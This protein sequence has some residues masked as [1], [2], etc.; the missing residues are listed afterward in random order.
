MIRKEELTVERFAK[1]FDMAVLAPDTQEEAIRQACR[2][3]AAHN[4]AAMYT[5]PC[6]TKVVAEELAGTDVRVGV[7]ISFPYGTLTTNMKM[8][9]IDD[10]IAN[11]GNSLDMVINIGALK[12]GNIDLVREEI[13]GLVDKAKAAGALSK[14][15]IEVGYLTD[16][17]IATVTKIVS[18][19]GADYVKTATGSAGLPDVH[20]LKVM[21]ANVSGKTKL[22]LSGVPRQFVLSAC[23]RM[24]EMGVELIGTR[25]SCKIVDEYAEYLKEKEQA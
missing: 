6:W 20:Q 4:L 17:E 7:A 14:V 16:E 5:T 2:D 9:E 22:K 24:L 11:G 3:A 10:A 21:K 13:Q 25:S 23:L 15:I 8:A 18:E 1:C 19:C 12:D